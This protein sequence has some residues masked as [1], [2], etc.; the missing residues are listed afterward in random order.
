MR[1]DVRPYGQL[2]V[3]SRAQSR[4]PLED[5]GFDFIDYGLHR[6][7]FDWIANPCNHVQ[8]SRHDLWRRLVQILECF[9]GDDLVEE[10]RRRTLTYSFAGGHPPHKETVIRVSKPFT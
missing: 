10:V 3:L 8:H 6:T 2:S 7:T 9:F 4:V 1:F 5:L